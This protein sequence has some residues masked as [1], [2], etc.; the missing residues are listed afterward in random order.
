MVGQQISLERALRQNNTGGQIQRL[1]LVFTWYLN[2]KTNFK[3][4]LFETYI[5]REHPLN[6]VIDFKFPNPAIIHE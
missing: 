4:I 2:A 6:V 1:H 5:I 3:R